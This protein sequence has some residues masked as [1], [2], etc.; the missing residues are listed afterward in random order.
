VEGNVGKVTTWII[1]ALRDRKF[2]ELRD[3]NEA[4]FEKLLAFNTKDFK[5]KP[6]SR[7]I[8]YT[9]EEK[10]FMQPLPVETYVL[11]VWKKLTPG[12]NYHITYDKNY[13][14]VPFQYIKHEVDLRIT[15]F[16]IEVFADGLRICAHP[17]LYGKSG[18][19]STNP[20][21]MPEKHRKYGEW[22]SERFIKWARSIGEHT[23]T[24]T[25]A[26]LASHVIEQ[27]GYR[28][29]MG[30]L[31]LAERNSAERLEAAC[32]RALTYTPS[33]TY[34]HIDSIIKSG[35]DKLTPN[36]VTQRE[37]NSPHSFVRGAD[38]YRR[39]KK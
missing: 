19:Y 12:F 35:Q 36:T 34:K 8:N 18:Q 24:A 28:A 30:V 37:A 23:E 26:I 4:V 16:I 3:L 25:R 27:Q 6:G 38:Y 1:A 22:N 32:K 17:R 33:P 13:Y 29:L 10:E 2:F 7:F 39:D 5:A 11:A 15:S 20:E 21:H 14:S 9:E 31:K